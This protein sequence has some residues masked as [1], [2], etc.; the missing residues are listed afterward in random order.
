MTNPASPDY[1]GYRFPAEIIGHAVRL[2]FRSPLSPRDVD[3][4]SAARGITVGHET[5]RRWAI[6][7]GQAFADRIR[8]RLPRV[9][10]EWR[11]DEVAVKIA[12]RGKDF[13]AKFPTI[14]IS[15]NT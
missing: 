3:E 1:A 6:E 11:P 14:A 2:H 8:R 5:V 9:G 12:E 10:D 13:S 15:K 7:F 4:P